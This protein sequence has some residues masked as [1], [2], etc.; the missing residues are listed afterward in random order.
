MEP[1]T[2]RMASLGSSLSSNL[3]LSVSLSL[4]I[5]AFRLYCQFFTVSVLLAALHFLSCFCFSSST[6]FC[7]RSP[8]RSNDRFVSPSS[9]AFSYVMVPPSYILWLITALSLLSES[10]VHAWINYPSEGTATLTHYELPKVQVLSS[11]KRGF[12]SFPVSHRTTLPR[13]DARGSLHTTPPRP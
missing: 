2:T 4:S 1:L 10:S 3:S 11:Q 9:S 13:V 8:F 12:A 5:S 7:R 6:R